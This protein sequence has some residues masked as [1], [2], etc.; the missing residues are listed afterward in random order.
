MVKSAGDALQ[1]GA[2][3]AFVFARDRQNYYESSRHVIFFLKRHQAV[4]RKGTATLFLHK[5]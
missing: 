4:I 2:L 1:Y 5:Q 3:A